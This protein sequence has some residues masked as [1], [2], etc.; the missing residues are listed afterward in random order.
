MK[1]AA[2]PFACLLLL[3]LAATTRAADPL[4]IT[5]TAGKASR[6]EVAG[7][8]DAEIAA[9]RKAELASDRMKKLLEVF[10]AGE[11]ADNVAAAVPLFGRLRFAEG[12]LAFEPRYPFLPGVA[13]RAVVR[14]ELISD[15]GA[16][17][18]AGKTYEFKIPETVR[19]P[20]TVVS[21]VYPTADLLPENQLKLYLHFS[22]PM[23]R[24]RVYRHI[25]LLRAD[26]SEVDLP[27]LELDEELWDSSG[28][29]LTVLFDPGRIKRGLKPREE[30]GPV[31]EEGKTY[32]LVIDA[33]WEDA[34]GQPLLRPF[35]KTFKSAAPDDVQPDHK[36][37]KLTPPRSGTR[38]PLVVRFNEP[39]DHAMLERVLSVRPIAGDKPGEFLEGTVEV[40]E[41]ETRWRFTPAAAWKP[42]RHAIA[43]SAALEDRAGNSIRRPFEVDL[44]EKVDGVIETPTVSLWFNTA[45]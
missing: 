32:T 9:L 1:Y 4:T 28:R 11:G 5:H 10:V 3:L 2:V 39:L 27:F 13:Y 43:V 35:R 31:L 41:G 33:A 23:S 17:N 38:Q 45:K 25:H 26:G 40:D 19:E 30:V 7:W 36:Q 34:N 6:V 29:R 14:R 22:A 37:W 24:G 18:S 12:V 20:S 8:N 44:F 16:A 15:E 21:Q 42:G